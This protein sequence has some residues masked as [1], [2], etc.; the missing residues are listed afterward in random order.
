MS[1]I[2]VFGHKRPDSD[3]ICSALAYA[4]LKKAL[5]IDAVAMKLGELNNETRFILKYFNLEEPETLYTI[6]TQVSDLDIDEAATVPP[7]IT[8][9]NAW[10]LLKQHN[11]KT[12][13]IVDRSGKLLGLATLSDITKGYMD[14]DIGALLAESKTPYMNIIN[15]L[16]AGIVSGKP[17]RHFAGGRVMI[18]A[19]QHSKIRSHIKKG[20]IVIAGIPEN[21]REAIISGA[22]LII[23]TCGSYPEETDIKIAEDNGCDIITTTYD[24]FA[25]AIL[26]RQ[27][28]PVE[29]VMTADNIITV[30]AGEFKDDVRE[31]ML[32]TRHRNYPVLDQNGRVLGTIARFH[33][34][35]KK[36]KQ[37]ILVDH[38]EISQTAAGIEQAEILE[39][40]DH[41]RLGD[42]QT[43]NPILMKNEPVGS[44]ATII[45]SAYE[46]N[47]IAMPSAI[48]GILLSAILSDTLNF[49]SPTCTE[50][51]RVIAKRLGVIADVDTA[52]LALKILNAGSTLRGKTIDEIISGDLKYYN[53]GKYGVG[54]A[55][56]YSIDFEN[57][58]DMHSAILD[59]M[60][61]YCGSKGMDLFMLLV[62]DL[63][64]GGS[65]VLLAGEMKSMFFKA[66]K[67]EPS[68][69]SVF[70]PGV[71]SRKKQVIP[72]IMS[73]EDEI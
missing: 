42:I 67:L 14:V 43:T 41:H 31:L 36:R 65:E 64:R 32:K 18:A 35:S 5:G 1:V 62:T 51:D 63:N 34:L 13:I 54:V 47:N 3:S 71:L 40:I 38:N 58:S 46:K 68:A 17:E 39:I 23:C 2:Y 73:V 4:E 52:D 9:H 26:I 44:T 22:E 60:Q 6:K 10:E 37:A 28:I 48:A 56:V 59:K 24:T 11:K 20:D 72:Q 49:Q 30:N 21:I 16:R 7:E 57:L 33:L 27:S 61:Y 66:Y 50:L 29:Y 53:V 19:Q 15:T 25:A 70:L 55:Q 8:I 69:G 12:L 45:A